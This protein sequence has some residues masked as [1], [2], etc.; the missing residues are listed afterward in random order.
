MYKELHT[1]NF[2]MGLILFCQSKKAIFEAKLCVNFLIFHK[3]D[4]KQI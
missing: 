4:Y 1:G 3:L 2:L